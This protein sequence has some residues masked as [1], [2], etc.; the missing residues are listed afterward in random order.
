M[1]YTVY[2]ATDQPLTRSVMDGDNVC[3]FA[4]GQTG[5]SGKTHT[6]CGPSGGS[7]KDMEIQ[8]CTSNGGL[9]LLDATMHVVKSSMDD[10]LDLIKLGEMNRFVSATAINHQ[11]SRSHSVLTVHAHGKDASGS[12][13]QNCLHL[14]DVAGS[15]RV[16]KSEVT[17]DRL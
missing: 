7:S 14:V 8:N 9:S 11:S 6:M 3:I 17:G 12:I 16:D 2:K 4:Y 15:E 13:L 10:V 5:S 1:R